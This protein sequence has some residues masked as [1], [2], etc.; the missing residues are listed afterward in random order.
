MLGDPDV[1]AGPQSA[2]RNNRALPCR[3]SGSD[4]IGDK[5]FSTQVN[6]GS[7]GALIYRI[8]L[9]NPGD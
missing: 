8:R 2:K 6:L 3:P 1:F 7:C 4:H 5:G 9:T